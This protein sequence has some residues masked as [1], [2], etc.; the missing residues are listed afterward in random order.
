MPAKLARRGRVLV[1]AA[2]GAVVVG[3]A[4]LVAG[5]G[6]GAVRH[7]V[8]TASPPGQEVN[9]DPAAVAQARRNARAAHGAGGA[10]ARVVLAVP[11]GEASQPDTPPRPNASGSA[12]A[13]TDAEIEGE[14]STFRKYLATIPPTTGKRAAVIS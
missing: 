6:G 3:V 10:H 11:P 8:P 4:A 9:L 13:Q 1:G 12:R 14:L 2:A 7:L 5:H